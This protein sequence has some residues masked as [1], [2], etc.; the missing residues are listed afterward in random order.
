MI[1][2]SSAAKAERNELRND[3]RKVTAAHNGQEKAFPE[4]QFQ[5]Y[6]EKS[7]WGRNEYGQKG[8]V[9]MV[10]KAHF[11]TEEDAR[12]ALAAFRALHEDRGGIKVRRGKVFRHA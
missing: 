7:F 10:I 12:A 5:M 1:Q 3:F 2:I 4:A 9:E 11:V 8:H 6:E